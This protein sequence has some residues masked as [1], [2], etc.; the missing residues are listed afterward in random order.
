MLTSKFCVIHCF[1]SAIRLEPY[2][3]PDAFCASSE[4]RCHEVACDSNAILTAITRTQTRIGLAFHL[5]VIM[6][7][8]QLH[9]DPFYRWCCLVHRA[10]TSAERR[11]SMAKPQ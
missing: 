8:S 5:P 9:A 2:I 11:T 7:D 6:N 3:I 10:K 1:P 4:R